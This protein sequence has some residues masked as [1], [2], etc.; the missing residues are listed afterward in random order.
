MGALRGGVTIFGLMR[1]ALS[2]STVRQ[3]LRYMILGLAFYGFFVATISAESEGND[4][5]PSSQAGDDIY[6]LF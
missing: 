1:F 2:K 6:P 3:R 5:A 4:S